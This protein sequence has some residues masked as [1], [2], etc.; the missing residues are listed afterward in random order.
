MPVA[1]AD[2]YFFEVGGGASLRSRAFF[3]RCRSAFQRLIGR[4]PRPMGRL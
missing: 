2:R 1:Q 3:F 4:E